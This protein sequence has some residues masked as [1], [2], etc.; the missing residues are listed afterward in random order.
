MLISVHFRVYQYSTQMLSNTFD[1]K[2]KC[3]EVFQNCLSIYTAVATFG[4]PIGQRSYLW[5]MLGG[6]DFA[7]G[8][9]F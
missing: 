7:E 6:L 2:F 4:F 9:S 1:L 3:V 5:T 8:D